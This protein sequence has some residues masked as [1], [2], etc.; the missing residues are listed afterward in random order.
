M[1]EVNDGNFEAE[2]LQS[3]IPALVD[4]WAPWCGP[5]KMITPVLEELATQ[6]EGKIKIVKMNVDDSPNTPTKYGVRGIPTLI[7]FQG[8]T[9]VDKI[10]GAAPKGKLEAFLQKVL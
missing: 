7:M 5:C 10:V 6:Y 8:G 9:E 4:F 3:E 2:I 1:R